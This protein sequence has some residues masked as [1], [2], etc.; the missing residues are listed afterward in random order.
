MPQGWA[1]E[2]AWAD[3]VEGD[4]RERLCDYGREALSIVLR[5]TP[6]RGRYRLVTVG[7]GTEA[8][9]YEGREVVG[10]VVLASGDVHR[11]H[12]LAVLQRRA[13]GIL[14]DTRRLVLPVRGPGD[15]RDAINY[16]SFWWA[17]DEPRG[18]AS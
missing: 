10:C 17:G 9:D 6:A 12:E 8:H 7:S 13:A 4:R 14:T 16:T 18:W 11:V 5:S 1:C 15:E 3:L 2:R